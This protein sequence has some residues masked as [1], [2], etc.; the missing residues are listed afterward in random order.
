M[1]LS[2]DWKSSAIDLSSSE[3]NLSVA[4]E[5]LP[6]AR[7]WPARIRAQSVRRCSLEAF[8]AWEENIFSQS[9]SIGSGVSACSPGSERSSSKNSMAI[10]SLFSAF[11]AAS[12]ICPSIR[13]AFRPGSPAS[14]SMAICPAAR[15]RASRFSLR[16]LIRSRSPS[17]GAPTRSTAPPSSRSR[18]ATARLLAPALTPLSVSSAEIETSSMGAMFLSLTTTSPAWP[19]NQPPL[20]ARWRPGTLSPRPA[21]CR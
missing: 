18:A 6:G 3:T 16:A 15:M 13:E 10:A 11:R 9:G 17:T 8:S 14:R 12:A 4:S 7:T 21:P 1:E 19:R 20:P 2:R 5:N